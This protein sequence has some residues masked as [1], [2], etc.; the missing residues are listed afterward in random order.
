[1]ARTGTAG[2]NLVILLPGRA[3]PKAGMTN[4]NSNPSPVG[5][6]RA[7]ALAAFLR[8]SGW[9][10]AMLVLGTLALYWPARHLPFINYDDPRYVT[11]N[12]PVLAGLSW[13]NVVWAFTT[14]HAE[15]WHPVTWLSLM[16]DASLFGPSPAGFH[17]TSV[18]LHAVNSALLFWLLLRLPG[19]RC[20]SNPSPG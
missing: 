15:N 14:G 10:A 7:P 13:D 11:A 19:I 1:M 5:S 18:L 16:L 12:P 6:A 9:L 3:G 4:P 8:P 17:V 2:V 20:T